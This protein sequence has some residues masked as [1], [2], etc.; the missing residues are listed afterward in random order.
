M[1]DK[2][3]SNKKQTVLFTCGGGCEL[4]EGDYIYI[5]GCE[6]QMCEEC[7]MDAETRDRPIIARA[8][9]ELYKSDLQS[10]YPDNEDD[11]KLALNLG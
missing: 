8:K 1:S 3:Q 5:F 6:T 4:F 10:N 2:K 11:V 7:A 9:L